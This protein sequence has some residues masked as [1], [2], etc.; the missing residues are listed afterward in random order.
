MKLR[1]SVLVTCT[2]LAAP[3]VLAQPTVL[4]P[5]DGL[6]NCV[7]A[8]FAEA[9]IPNFDGTQM[10]VLTDRNG[11]EV[12]WAE[13]YLTFSDN[14]AIEPHEVMS[15]SLSQEEGYQKNHGVDW[16]NYPQTEASL[17]EFAGGVVEPTQRL[18]ISMAYEHWVR[19]RANALL[20]DCL[21]GKFAI[22]FQTTE[23]IRHW[24]T[25]EANFRNAQQ[26]V[27]SCDWDRVIPP[28]GDWVSEDFADMF[29]SASTTQ[30]AAAVLEFQEK[31]QLAC[32]DA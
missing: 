9:A 1:P 22:E 25:L 3:P 12:S 32:P 6:R 21:S 18:N 15:S 17:F 20:Q 14:T 26:R 10:F 29:E 2:A 5:V 4:H 8:R 7:E 28:L 19:Q 16:F 13:H 23:D 24:R 30:T 31:A 27:S 11:P